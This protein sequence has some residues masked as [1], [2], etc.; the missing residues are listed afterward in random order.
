MRRTATGTTAVASTAVLTPLKGQVKG[1]ENPEAPDL[2][3]DKK[4]LLPGAYKVTLKAT[5]NR[6]SVSRVSAAS[7]IVVVDTPPIVKV[8][9][10]VD[11]LSDMAPASTYSGSG[12]VSVTGTS[13]SGSVVR[14]VLDGLG[15]AADLVSA[16]GEAAVNDPLSGIQLDFGY[17]TAA[18]AFVSLTV[19]GDVAANSFKVPASASAYGVRATNRH[20]STGFAQIAI[21]Y[22]ASIGFANGLGGVADVMSSVSNDIVS[23]NDV[24]D[25]DAGVALAQVAAVA[26]NSVEA[27]SGFE[28]FV[29]RRQLVSSTTLVAR[30]LNPTFPMKSALAVAE[31]TSNPKALDATARADTKRFLDTAIGTKIDYDVAQIL[32]DVTANLLI[33]I[34]STNA[35]FTESDYSYAGTT[36][37]GTML[38]RLMLGVTSADDK[39]PTG[40]VLS[41]TSESLSL[42]GTK[43]GSATLESE[44]F[45][46]GNFVLPKGMKNDGVNAGASASETSIAA[47]YA[48]E[49][50]YLVGKMFVPT[51]FNPYEWWFKPNAAFASTAQIAGLKVFSSE[52]KAR[53]QQQVGGFLE[54]AVV[55]SSDA[56]VKVTLTRTSKLEETNEAF[57]IGYNTAEKRF[58]T[59]FATTVGTSQE[60]MATECMVAR[61]TDYTTY[62][63]VPPSPPPPPSPPLPPAPPIQV[64]EKID[65]LPI[66]LGVLAGFIVL[67]IAA[68][69]LYYK[70]A[71]DAA[72]ERMIAAAEDQEVLEVQGLF[73]PSA[74]VAPIRGPVAGAQRTSAILESDVL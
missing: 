22:I 60:G 35:P 50:L 13:A 61:L 25:Y 14:E 68:A 44:G 36:L 55:P 23:L 12:T 63:A 29:S 42:Y 46:I 62:D 58:M 41:L 21:P 9:A 18:G 70:R 33:S 3:L 7:T 17:F 8:V 45:Q 43:V 56:P 67:A 1:G 38:D 19:A 74:K 57:C 32:V 54:A 34:E 53:R 49:D 16:N 2:Y 5:I 27:A 26:L 28:I 30:L 69:L 24:K 66:V 48:G 72:M 71:R 73:D 37:Y 4:A 64:E 51:K 39:F 11:A 10:A 31:I 40:V 47:K 6:G 65:P 20:G 59:D 52:T 15:M